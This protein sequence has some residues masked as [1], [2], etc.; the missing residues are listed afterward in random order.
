VKKL[1]FI[2]GIAAIATSFASCNADDDTST[3]IEEYQAWYDTN[4]AWLNSELTKTN[5]DNTPFYEPVTPTWAVG[6]KIYMHWFND[7]SETAGNLR[8]YKTSYVSTYYKGY[9]CNGSLFDESEG[10]AQNKEDKD[11][12]TGQV[13][14]FISGWQIALQNMHVGDTVQILVPYDLAYGQS[15]SGSIQPYSALRFNM[16]L[17]DIPYYEVRP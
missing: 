4:V 15:G 16:R 10:K 8:P 17:V 12:F 13:A 3:S 2:L 9:L 6:Q 11:L 7:R 14:Q 5:P 1:L